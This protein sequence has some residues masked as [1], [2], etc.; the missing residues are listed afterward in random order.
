MPPKNDQQP[1][2]PQSATPPVGDPKPETLDKDPVASAAESLD[3]AP[4]SLEPTSGSPSSKQSIFNTVETTDN[5]EDDEKRPNRIVLAFKR[6][7]KYILIFVAVL[8][9]IV[10]VIFYIIE[11]NKNVA[12]V[13]TKNQS[14]S[15]TTLSQLNSNSVAIGGSQETLDIQSNSVFS[16]SALVK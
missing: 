5:D 10:F 1:T 16:G 6:F 12:P 3:Q 7:D 14:L 15:Q 8:I 2:T 4:A 13:T 9:A 11:T